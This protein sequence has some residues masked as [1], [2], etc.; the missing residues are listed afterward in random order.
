MLAL[1]AGLLW[2]PAGMT[3]WIDVLSPAIMIA[4]VVLLG[5]QTN[6][7]L[8]ALTATVTEPSS[9]TRRAPHKHP[10]AR[11]SRKLFVLPLLRALEWRRF[12]APRSV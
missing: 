6:G 8:D 12:L 9:T 1:Q 3:P 5:R 10:H 11:G 4:V 2:H 7:H